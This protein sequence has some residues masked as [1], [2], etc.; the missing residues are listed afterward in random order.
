MT[1]EDLVELAKAKANQQ[2]A[3]YVRRR[4]GPS[5][6]FDYRVEGPFRGHPT[7]NIVRIFV[8]GKCYTRRIA[9]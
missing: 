8:D 2:V 4:F 5:R 3:K 9:W 7:T 1:S 6:G